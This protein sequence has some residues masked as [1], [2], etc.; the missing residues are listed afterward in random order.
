MR[1]IGLLIG[2]GGRAAEGGRTFERRDPVTGEVA[3]RAA[4]ATAAD[5]RAAVEK[6]AQAFKEWSELGPTA[7]RKALLGAADALDAKAD[8][9]VKAMMTETGAA[10][11]W[12]RFNVMLAGN[13]L[14]EAAALTTQ[15]T[16]NVIPSDVPGNMAMGV[17]QPVGVVVGIAP[18]NAPVILGTRAVA[19]PLAVGNSVILKASEVCPA[20]HLLIGEA[21]IEGGVPEGVISVITNDPKDAKEVVDAL[22]EHPAVKRIS[23][24]GSTNVGRKIA[25]KAAEQLKPVLLELG[26][27]APLVVLDDADIDAAVNAA[28]FG[29]F[30]HQGQICMSTE[31]IIVDEKIADEFVEKLAVRARGVLAADP[32]DGNTI[33][34]SLVD[35]KEAVRIH[36]MVEDAREKGADVMVGGTRDGSLMP[37]TVIDRVTP[38]MS[39]YYD[40]SFGPVV[41]IVRVN[42]EE[43]A[44]AAANDSEFGLSSAVFTRDIARG[45]AVARRIEAGICHVNGPTVHDE[46]QMPFGGV[47]SSGYGRFGGTQSIN[48]FTELRWI[49]VQMGPRD[50]PF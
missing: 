30:M 41:V 43:E 1:E 27:K 6:A 45:L 50:Y 37:A 28:T 18:W 39:L 31:R 4:A 14:R 9:F 35:E 2:A 38:E 44:I 10:E 7:R 26:G 46:A 47:K 5:A 12:A 34:A 24:T 19:V 49:T 25:I 48:E 13:M 8:A 22:I 33:L 3:T 11:C 32:R 36:G 21:L 20:T 16:G 29:A 23:F 17:R 15:V 40:E 42:G